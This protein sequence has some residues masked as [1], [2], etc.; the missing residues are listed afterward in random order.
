MK[1]AHKKQTKH[2]IKSMI[3]KKCILLLNFAFFFN[4]QIVNLLAA[5]TFLNAIIKGRKYEFFRG[6]ESTFF[7]GVNGVLCDKKWEM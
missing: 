2:T 7:C 4:S 3:H 5:A 1:L 6:R